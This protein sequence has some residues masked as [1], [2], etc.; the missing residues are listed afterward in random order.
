MSIK[1]KLKEVAKPKFNVGDMVKIKDGT[2]APFEVVK[3]EMYR[4]GIYY[5]SANGRFFS[6]EQYLELHEEEKPQLT[7]GDVPVGSAFIDNHG[8]FC[9]K[10]YES[11][12]TGNVF[13]R[14]EISPGVIALHILPHE[15]Y[16]PI[17]RIIPNIEISEV[18]P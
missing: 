12:N 14:R 1:V 4:F 3:I 18:E 10:V 9:I 2:T 11:E 13:S 6:E 16:W 15:N 8:A 7:F 5:W 17:Q